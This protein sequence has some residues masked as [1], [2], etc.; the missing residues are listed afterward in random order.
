MTKDSENSNESVTAAS[1]AAAAAN[2]DDS[3]NNPNNRGIISTRATTSSTK[4]WISPWIVFIIFLY[5]FI[6]IW[7]NY[8]ILQ[9]Y[10]IKNNWNDSLPGL[11]KTTMRKFTMRMH[12]T[13]GAIAMLL[14]PIQFVPY[15]RRCQVHRWTG[16]LYCICGM[17]TSIFGLWFI[18]LKQRLVGGYNMTAAFSFAGIAIGVLSFKAWRT[19]RSARYAK[20]QSESDNK[21]TFVTHRNWGIR[22][23]SQI[24]AP[25]LYR[26]WYAMMDLF[27]LYKT[28]T[29]LRL[30]GYCD[31]NDFCPDYARTWD[32]LYCWVYWISAWVVAEIIIYCLPD[33]DIN[34]DKPSATSDL[35]T[36][37]L[38]TN[39][40]QINNATSTPL[41]TYG[42][43][44][45]SQQQ[46]EGSLPSDISQDDNNT[47]SR[48]I[49]ISSSTPNNNENR[50]LVS[51]VNFMGC[52]LAVTTV[53]ISG[54]TFQMIVDDFSSTNSNDSASSEE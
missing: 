9:R 31:A 16:R 47:T 7:M 4:V 30:G 41:T 50:D 36:P 21:A 18:S 44:D 28:P 20:E 23:Y 42:S 54:K 27:H 8:A 14:G 24:I 5:V 49:E 38:P 46:Q 34:D 32:A 22:S 11:D 35:T 45:E 1:A 39:E 53:V 12:M 17:L 10:W 40:E 48:N 2:D 37:L 52:L 43:S 13:T 51:V 25:A 26:Y 29:P 3:S 6:L 33:Y 19:A 15:L